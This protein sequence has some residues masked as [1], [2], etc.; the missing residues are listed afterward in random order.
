MRRNNP[1][2]S[3][4]FSFWT[5]ASYI[6]QCIFK[7]LEKEQRSK[8]TPCYLQ[9][10]FFFKRLNAKSN[11]T[12]LLSRVENRSVLNVRPARIFQTP[13][14]SYLSQNFICQLKIDERQRKRFRKKHIKIKVKLH[15]GQ[16]MNGPAVNSQSEMQYKACCYDA[17]PITTNTSKDMA[18]VNILHSD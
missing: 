11:N 16:V 6:F 17:S 15:R 12:N 18:F 7:L 8:I 4:R 1:T 9:E 10:D 2:N 5:Y 13:C 14:C 3:M